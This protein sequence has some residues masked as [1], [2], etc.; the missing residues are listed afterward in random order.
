MI[1]TDIVTKGEVIT[2]TEK[3]YK[4]SKETESEI[5]SSVDII[6]KEIGYEKEVKIEGGKIEKEIESNTE[7]IKEWNEEVKTVT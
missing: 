3:E 2:T 1:E 7:T 4:E 5:I 6:E